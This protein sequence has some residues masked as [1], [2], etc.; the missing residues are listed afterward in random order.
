MALAR[1]AQGLCAMPK[2]FTRARKL[3]L[4]PQK[5]PKKRTTLPELVKINKK[6]LASNGDSVTKIG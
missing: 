3:W 6:W 4:K 5:S 1:C 2:K